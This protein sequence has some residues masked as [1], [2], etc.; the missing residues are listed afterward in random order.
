[1]TAKEMWEKYRR[2]AGISEDTP[3]EAWHFCNNEKDA[4]E[5]AELTKKGIKRGTAGMLKSYEADN[6]PIPKVG[7]F[8]VITD[9]KE[10]G[11]C[12]IQVEKVEILPFGEITEEHARIEGE[13]DKSLK[14]WGEGHR[15]FFSQEAEELGIEFNEEIEVVFETF[16][17]VY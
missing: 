4:N 15:K 9:W 16:K 2:E 14:Y 1:M 10:N 7:N 5:L 6:E 12:I 11:V 3:Y 17:V 13:G 8:I